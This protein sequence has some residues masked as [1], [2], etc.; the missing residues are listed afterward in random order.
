MAN[1]VRASGGFSRANM[2][3]EFNRGQTAARVG[4]AGTADVLVGKTFTNADVSGAEG[5]MPNKGSSNI[6]LAA[7]STQAGIPRGYYNGN[8]IIDASAV[9]TQGRNDGY[10]SG[11]ADWQSSVSSTA[12]QVWASGSRVTSFSS[13]YT[14]SKKGILIIFINAARF[15]SSNTEPTL[16]GMQIHGATRSL[17]GTLYRNEDKPTS[18][19]ERAFSNSG[20]WIVEVA[21]GATVTWSVLIA[22]AAQVDYNHTLIAI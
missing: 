19:P 18:A 7:S 21:A 14:A 2:T 4:T 16:S 11:H 5:A 8:G 9:Y 20:M 22:N 12:Q 13:S 1:M 6:V 17:S 15:S 3:A 10:A